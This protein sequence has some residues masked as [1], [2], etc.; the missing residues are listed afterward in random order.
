MGGSAAAQQQSMTPKELV[1]CRLLLLLSIMFSS[2]LEFFAFLAYKYDSCIYDMYS[3]E[4]FTL[5]CNSAEHSDHKH[6]KGNL[7]DLPNAGSKKLIWDVLSKLYTSLAGLCEAEVD[8]RIKYHTIHPPT[9]GFK[10]NAAESAKLG[11]TDFAKMSI[12]AKSDMAIV[13]AARALEVFNSVDSNP[14]CRLYLS[15]GRVIGS[16]VDAFLYIEG[17]L[18]IDLQKLAY[19]FLKKDEVLI[20]PNSRI[21]TAFQKVDADSFVNDDIFYDQIYFD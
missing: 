6:C 1:G 17:V 13:S 9:E 3:F 5:C 15:D 10:A 11:A 19:F 4:P 8:R 2:D 18:G 16:M 7:L 21:F 20:L 14:G 12:D